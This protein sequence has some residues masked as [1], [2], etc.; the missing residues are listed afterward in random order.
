MFLFFEFVPLHLYTEPVKF[1]PYFCFSSIRYEHLA[2]LLTQMLQRKADNAVGKTRP[3]IMSIFEL[4]FM[5]I[6]N[7]S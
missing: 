4:N 6:V 5:A 2:S 3:K 1:S 7:F